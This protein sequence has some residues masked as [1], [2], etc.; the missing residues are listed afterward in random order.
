MGTSHPG[1]GGPALHWEQAPIPL[2]LQETLEDLDKNK[3][4]Y[5]Q[6]DEYIGE[7]DPNP[8]LRTPVPSQVQVVAQCIITSKKPKALWYGGGGAA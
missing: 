5:I 2:S 7:W 1:P 8:S 4:G 3:D 6:V